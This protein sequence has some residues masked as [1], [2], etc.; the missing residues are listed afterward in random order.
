MKIITTTSIETVAPQDWNK[1][2]DPNSPFLD[3]EFLEALEKSKCINDTTT[4]KSLY[5]LMY[6][7]D[8]L[9]AALPFYIRYDS[10]GEFIFDFA[11]AEAYAK[12][13]LEYY[14]KGLCA[15]PFTPVNGIRFLHDKN[16]SLEEILD[17]LFP[18]ILKQAELLKLSSLHFLFITEE[19]KT[20]LEK[21]NCAT[22]F[23]IQ[24]HWKNKNYTDFNA[25]LNS[26]KASKRKNIKKERESITQKNLEI[27]LFT[28]NQITQKMMQTMYTFYINTN[29]SKW[30]QPYLNL[31]FF[32][33]L[34]ENLSSS[35]IL[36]LAFDKTNSHEEE[37]IAG[38]LN[39]IKGNKLA[40]RY[41]GCKR[42]YQNLHFELC[43]YQLIEYAITNKLSIVEAGAQGEHKF[44]RGF[45]ANIC[46]SSHYIFHPQ[47]RKSINLFLS[48]ERKLMVENLEAYNIQ[49]PVKETR[50]LKL[51]NFEK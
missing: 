32:M 10:R 11:W 44:L 42:E 38:T 20:I 4:W 28:G 27:K 30:G 6:E 48:Q 3:Y 19:E 39:F 26:L 7:K 45:D 24:F 37:M 2:S 41:W 51:E 25:Y 43:Y 31:N 18:E 36:I 14:P 40:G 23:D 5:F 50:K 35:I 9:I 33:S 12:W 47:A 49:S 29:M 8:A 22:R 15:I 16:Y 13:G 21:Y 34:L 1:I 17:I 46:Y